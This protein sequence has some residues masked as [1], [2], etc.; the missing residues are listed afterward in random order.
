VRVGVT[1]GIG[2]GKTTVSEI[3]RNQGAYVIEADEVGRRAVDD[4]GVRMDLVAA[5]GQEILD[6]K[7]DL[8]RRELG[9]RAFV[10]KDAKKILNG[11]VWPKLAELLED[12]TRHA[13]D[14]DSERT[15]VVDAALLLEWG[16]PK[17][18]CDV[19]VAVTAPESTR[20]QR[21]VA[22]LELSEGEVRDRMASQLPE[23]KKLEAAD[24]VILNDA[25]EKELEE[26]SLDVWSRIHKT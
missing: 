8:D 19:L 15:V 4:K 18:F 1:G 17:D 21:S 7:G 3:F 11:I 25:N 13:L 9:R 23:E 10:D 6:T 12:E 26:R 22:R 20:I 14:T 5:F 16:K 24:F 2:A